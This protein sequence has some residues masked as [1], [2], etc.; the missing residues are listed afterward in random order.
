MIETE[1]EIKAFKVEVKIE[2]ILCK[3]EGFQ[4]SKMW[5]FTK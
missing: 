5:P 4:I 1:E 2:Q 3:R